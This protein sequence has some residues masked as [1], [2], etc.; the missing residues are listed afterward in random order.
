MSAPA[1]AAAAKS[2]KLA[3][4]GKRTES[5][6]TLVCT[7]AK[8]NNV[9]AI[10]VKAMN[11]SRHANQ[12]APAEYSMRMKEPRR[13]SPANRTTWTVTRSKLTIARPQAAKRDENA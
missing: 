8:N 12:K 2:N 10:H 5:S 4:Q 1:V 7:P 9:A 11:F 3:C 6:D 13:G